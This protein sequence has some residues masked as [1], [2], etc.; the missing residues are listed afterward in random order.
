M[1]W[2][3]DPTKLATSPKDRMRFE[4]GDVDQNDPLLQDEE[5]LFALDTTNSF[6][7]AK[8]KCAEALANRYAHEATTKTGPLAYELGQ[9]A[10]LWAKKL[11]QYK[12]EAAGTGAPTATN[13]DKA[14][15]FTK[16]MHDYS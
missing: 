7:Y 5:I 3:Y 11:A 1:T 6:A 4:I 9:R 13:L 2:S 15:S 8:V 14:P 16:G 12:S 10:E